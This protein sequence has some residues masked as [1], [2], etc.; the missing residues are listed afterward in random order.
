M[1]VDDYD[2]IDRI[3]EK[4]EEMTSEE[5]LEFYNKHFN[6]NGLAVKHIFWDKKKYTQSVD[7]A[8]GVNQ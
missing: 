7:A 2:I 4:L 8:K 1:V 5:L 6:P 3:T